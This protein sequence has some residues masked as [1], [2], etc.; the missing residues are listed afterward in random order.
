[1]LRALV[2]RPIQRCFPDKVIARMAEKS[3]I[4]KQ[5]IRLKSREPLGIP[6]EVSYRLP[7]LDVPPAG[8]GITAVE[9]LKY[10]SVHLFVLRAKMCLGTFE[11][12]DENA[13]S[14]ARIVRHVDGIAPAIELAAP[15]VKVLTLNQLDRRLDDH[16]TRL[17]GGHRTAQPRHKTMSALIS[18]S[19][20][21]LSSAEQR[22]LQ[23]RREGRTLLDRALRL[24]TD[25]MPDRARGLLAL[26]EAGDGSSGKA[27][28]PAAKAA[29][30]LSGG[31]DDIGYIEATTLHGIAL[32][33]SGHVGEALRLFEEAISAVRGTGMPRLIGWVL[34]M[35]AYWMVAARD[36]DRDR[37]AALF[38]EAS[39]HLRS[40]ND[41]WQLARLQLH[42]AEFFF[43]AD[44][45]ERALECVREAESVYRTRNAFSGLCVCV[46]N[47]AAYLIALARLDEALQ[48]AREGLD[49]SQKH[50]I[51]MPG[52][53]A[54]GHLARLAAEHGDGERAARLLG[55]TGAAYQRTGS[56][57]EPTEQRGYDRT[58][59]LI[60]AALAQDRVAAL[61]S[62]GA[63]LEH[64]NAVAEAS[65]VSL[66]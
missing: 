3:R 37:A 50:G 2:R 39:E 44:D 63:L 34:S 27:A 45:P 21:L 20:E 52:A 6:G 23:R 32:G 51:T 56:A 61:M 16:L 36:R 57:R 5:K 43:D 18:W 49:L 29:A 10:S 59:E 19:Y 40:C 28:V 55:Y 48:A 35:A 42:R 1:M 7:A 66:K 17:S 41:A 65:A 15:R 64:E 54:I 12:T 46:I 25:G 4:R 31:V 9:A 58:L 11:I 26:T 38:E 62:Q 22:L 13:E 60:G 30:T 14:V 33:R 8:E 47:A 24:D 53:W